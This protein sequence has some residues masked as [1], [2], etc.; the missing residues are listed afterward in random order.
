MNETEQAVNALREEAQN[1]YE[2]ASDHKKY[3]SDEAADHEF[4]RAEFLSQAADDL[5]RFHKRHMVG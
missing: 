4:D 5:E 3:G 1:R 2:S